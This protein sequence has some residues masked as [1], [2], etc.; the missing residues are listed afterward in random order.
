MTVR[1]IWIPDKTE[2]VAERGMVVAKHPLA[3]EAGI[4]VLQEGGNAVDAAVA[5]GFALTVVKPMMTCIAGIGYLLAHD[6]ARGEQWCFDAA[7]RAPLAAHDHCYEVIGENTDGIGLYRVRGDEN[8]EGHRAAAVPGLVAALCTAHERLGRLP[9]ERVLEPAIRLAAEGWTVDWATAL[10]AANAMP[11]LARNSAAA[12]IFLPGGFPPRSDAPA[13]VLK[14]TDLAET[15]RRIAKFGA[16]GFYSGDVAHAIADDM[17]E[18]GGWITAED[19]ARYP[20]H[21]DAPRRVSYRGVT[22]LLPPM[23]CGA[24]TAAETL[25]ILER[26]D[27]AGAGHNTVA[28]LHLFIEA[29]RRAFADRFHYLGDPEVVPVPLDGLLS[30]EHADELAALVNRERASFM[31][32]PGDPEPWARFA[33]ERPAGDPWRFEAQQRATSFAGAGAAQPDDSCTTHLATVDAERNAV[34]LTITAAGLFGAKVVSKGTGVLWNNGMTWFNPR[35]GAANSIAPGKRALTNMTPLILLRDGKPWVLIGAPGGR[36]IVNAITQIVLN[37]VDHGL[38]MQAAVGAPRIDASANEA[39]ADERLD[40][41]VVEELRARGHRLR[42]VA[43]SPGAASFSRPLGIMIDPATNRLHS[44]L[45]PFHLA[46]ARG[47]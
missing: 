23:A 41:A 35:P 38:G 43:D 7:P 30:E 21:V 15:L 46:E 4:E 3:A 28:G 29:A 19:L 13:S 18:H 1:S 9:R 5:M 11:G 12:E 34:C 36:K 22:V 2:V 37:V 17:R 44:G 47:Y 40:P 24:T 39:L 8:F 10:H 27:V 33:A 32:E 20:R 45:T 14:Q 42:E 25:K 16:D 26:F 6:A 31:S